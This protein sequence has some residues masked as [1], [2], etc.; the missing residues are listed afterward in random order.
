MAREIRGLAGQEE[1]RELELWLAEDPA[2]RK[3][4]EQVK[5][6]QSQKAKLEVYER[7]D[8]EKSRASVEEKLFAWESR[9]MNT[10]RILRY[11]AGI[12]LPLLLV[13]GL[14]W[15]FLGSPKE[16]LMAEID[17]HI[18]AGSQEAVLVLADGRRVAVGKEVRMEE[19]IEGSARILE[20][21]AGL[22]Y[23]ENPE[24]QGGALR[25][26][27]LQTQRGGTIRVRLADG[28]SVWLNSGSSLR[29]PVSFG[30][31]LRQVELQGEAYFEVRHGRKPFIVH[32]GQVDTRVLGTSFNVHAYSDDSA[33]RT[34]LVEGRVSVAWKEEG[35]PAGTPSILE[36]DQ[37]AS[38]R[39][40]SGELS[41]ESV[42]AAGYVS[43]VEGKMEFHRENLDQV[44][45][46]LSRWYD[47]EYRFENQAAR[48]LSF[49][50]RLDR[51]SPISEVLEML[52]MTTEVRFEFRDQEIIVH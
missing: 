40:E 21:D 27:E 46:Q 30:D 22:S 29:Y 9:S 7:F 14:A 11:A 2:N 5:N 20:D 24:G 25:Y 18:Q 32:S 34:T 28:S 6:A 16:D 26:N 36:P 15:I 23:S 31:S 49:S 43:W 19:L 3:L 50:A 10:F 48:K 42:E 17:T 12:V 41:V 39:Q 52:S 44:M 45:K 35:Q 47:F 1:C 13:G 38:F 33:I 51:S 37:Q 4:Y 8:L